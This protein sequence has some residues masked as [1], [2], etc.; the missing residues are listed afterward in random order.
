MKRKIFISFFFIL[1][2]SFQVLGFIF[3]LNPDIFKKSVDHI[4]KSHNSMKQIN[5][6]YPILEGEIEHTYETDGV[7]AVCEGKPETEN[8]RVEWINISDFELV[9]SR[10]E[11]FEPNETIYRYQG[12]DYSF[13]YHGRLLN[14]SEAEE[15]YNKIANIELLN[16]DNLVVQTNIDSKNIDKINYDTTAKMS[17]LDQTY[18]AKISEIGHVISDESLPV[19]LS[20]EH[21]LYP[22]S[23]V[24]VTFVTGIQQDGMY[25]PS[26]AVYHEQDDD[27]DYVL[28]EKNN[29]IIRK[30]IKTGTVFSVDENNNTFSYTEIVSGLSREDR[31]V[32][33][34]ISYTSDSLAEEIK[35]E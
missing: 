17:Y 4:D 20:C 22:G 28:V 7:I 6:Y 25:I 23:K 14:V 16:Y 12:K 29:E 32:T 13:P 9:K 2:L 1:L 34:T 15:D 8:I 26:E 18:D 30:V 27:V 24:K 31:I 35:N 11:L 21:T 33:Q 5:A 19:I 10:G 3:L